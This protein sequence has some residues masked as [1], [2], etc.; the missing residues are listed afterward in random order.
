[1]NYRPPESSEQPSTS[2]DSIVDVKPSKAELDRQ[3]DIKPLKE[4]LNKQLD[5]KPVIKKEPKQNGKFLNFIT[6]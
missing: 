2:S 5:I 3:M 6:F 4:E 1:L